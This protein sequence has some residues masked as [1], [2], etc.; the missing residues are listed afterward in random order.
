MSCRDIHYLAICVYCTCINNEPTTWPGTN[1]QN[2]ACETSETSSRAVIYSKHVQC[3]T[4][5]WQHKQSSDNYIKSK[6]VKKTY[7]SPTLSESRGVYAWGGHLEQ[8]ATSCFEKWHG[9]HKHHN[10]NKPHAQHLSILNPEIKLQIS[11]K[12][13]LEDL[14]DWS[15]KK[16][17]RKHEPLPKGK[18]PRCK[19]QSCTEHRWPKFKLEWTI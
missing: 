7:L 11:S 15:F 17:S 12:N 19:N 13:L 5:S 1:S 6:I 14:C 16:K 18:K 8:D 4:E 3:H 2:R 9:H 10:G